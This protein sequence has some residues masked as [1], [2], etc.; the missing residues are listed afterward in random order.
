M[1]SF[2]IGTAARDDSRVAL[3]TCDYFPGLHPDDVPLRDALRAR[4]IEPDVLCWDDPAVDWDRYAVAVIRS[5]WDYVPRRD[6]YVAWAHRVPHL[7]NPG[8]VISWNTDKRYLGELAAAGIPIIPT[9]FVEPGE[10]WDPPASGE[11]VV[12]PAV[13]A[14]SR[15]TAR[16]VLPDQLASAVAHAERLTVG[17]GRTAMIQP[18]LDA[19]DTDGETAVLCLPAER[20]PDVAGE[21]VFSHSI[22]KGPMLRTRGEGRIDAESEEITARTPSEAELD[23][24]E[25][26]LKVVPGGASRLLYARVDMI[27]GPDGTPLLAELELTEPCLFLRTAPGAAE[28][29]ADAIVA[30][31]SR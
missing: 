16:Y 9:T 19:V 13:S 31:V 2:P 18:F 30:R 21:L 25:R 10:T 24:A 11:W 4:G 20:H 14:G 6:A 22:R 8:D 7:V 17:E 26:V 3:V 23:L 1:T 27:P 29:L 5:T 12:K 15:D 28:R